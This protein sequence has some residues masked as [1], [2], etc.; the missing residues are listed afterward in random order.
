MIMD[1]GAPCLLTH[2]CDLIWISAKGL[3]VLLDELESGNLFAHA[4]GPNVKV[5]RIEQEVDK[6]D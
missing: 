1:T 3:N 5:I 6:D 2:D 4:G